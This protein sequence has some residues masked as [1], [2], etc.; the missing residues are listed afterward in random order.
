LFQNLK[1]SNMKNSNQ[2]TQFKSPTP[3]SLKCRF[4]RGISAAAIG[5]GILA[6]TAQD[7]SAAVTLT[8]DLRATAAGGGASLGGAKVVN[9]A[10]VGSTVTLELWAIIANTNNNQTNDGILAV[11]GSFLSIGTA[12]GTTG[13]WSAP[14]GVTELNSLLQ[15]TGSQNGSLSITSDTNFG[16]ADLGVTGGA[17]DSALPSPNRYMVANTNS[18]TTLFGTNNAT[19]ANLEFLIATKTFTIATA[20]GSPIQL[21]FS[22][23]ST[24]AISKPIKWT[25]DGVSLSRSGNSAADIAYTPNVVI[26]VVPEPSAFGMLLVGALGLV[27]FRRLGFRRT[28]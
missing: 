13:T 27:G 20:V 14:G 1:S 23:R 6:M 12:A 28:A 16:G 22:G 10:D 4:G 3:R 7:S 25:S 19:S 9:A 26:N 17:Q 5:F 21:N 2:S 8:F 24:S 15:G 11:A 18:L